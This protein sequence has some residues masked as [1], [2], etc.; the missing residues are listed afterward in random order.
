M[1]SLGGQRRWRPYCPATARACRGAICAS[2]VAR[3]QISPAATAD[4]RKA[5]AGTG[6]SAPLRERRTTHT[7]CGM[8]RWAAL[9]VRCW[10]TR[11]ARTAAYIGGRPGGRTTKIHAS[12]AALG[13][14]PGVPLTPG[15]ARD[16]AGAEG[17]WPELLARIQ[18][19]LADTAE[20][21]QKRGLAR[22]AGRHPAKEKPNSAAGRR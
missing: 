13:N 6:C 12:C 17:G 16:R 1:C 10:G 7:P 20:A 3:G 18:A 2:G 15:Q 5:A 8:R 4:G 22:G 11:G 21:A 9:A 14:P 19:W